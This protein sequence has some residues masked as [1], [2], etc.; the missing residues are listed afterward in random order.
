MPLLSPITFYLV[1]MNT[2]TTMFAAF[3]IIDVMTKGGPANSTT[4][5]IYRLYLDAFAFQRT[6]K[7]AA[8]SVILFLIMAVITIFYFRLVEK[9]VHYQ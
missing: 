4:T 1:I 7:A 5:M 2:I 9:R 8:E 6:G 3:A